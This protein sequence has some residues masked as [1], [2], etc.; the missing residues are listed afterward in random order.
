MRHLQNKNKSPSAAP[1]RRPAERP[2]QMGAVVSDLP[3]E[4]CACG[5]GCP[6]CRAEAQSSS[7]T[8]FMG[9][10]R[11]PAEH[12]ADQAAEPFM[13]LPRPD[14]KINSAVS[15]VAKN[16]PS[17]SSTE[18]KEAPAVVHRALESP[19]QPLDNDTRTV[20]ESHFR[21]SF[22]DVRVHGD[23]RGAASARA[24]AADAYAVGNDLVFGAGKYAPATL[25]GRHLLAHELAHVA[26]HE[27]APA[28]SPAILR[29]RP[30]TYGDLPSVAQYEWTGTEQRKTNTR[31]QQ[32]N[33]SLAYNAATG[34][35]T[36][37]FH[38][39]W[40]FPL[41]WAQARRDAYRDDF[42][43]VVKAAWENKFPL[44]KWENGKPTSTT[45][46]VLLDFD[47]ITAPDMG[48][49]DEYIQWLMNNNDPL[50]NQRWTMNIHDSF[51]YRDKVDAPNVHLDPGSNTPQTSDTSSFKDKTY[52]SGP[53]GAVQPPPYQ[54]YFNQGITPSQGTAPQGKYTQT[55][56]VH[57]FGH[58]IGLADEYVMSADDYNDLVAA[59]GQSVADTE[60]RKRTKASTRVENMGNQVTKD[61][62]RP[63]ADF[64]HTLTAEDWRVQ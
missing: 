26:Q 24:V 50:N 36:C 12:E 56:S 14:G 20:M 38:L 18:A 31:I 59:K 32:S 41:S 28:G 62:Y 44:V 3:P 63:F 35:F 51:T 37:T 9:S 54:H 2:S 34:D 60:L 15:P 45:A 48:N 19:G 4:T 61:A 16:Y 8:L 55:A 21:R 25:A 17:P 7:T 40:R 22:A 49:D 29:R 47:H 33:V 42:V 5:G 46:Q 27:T 52:T 43:K 58:M 1:S 13:R 53:G 10:V 23:A 30:I 11:D 39:R 57:E 6:R 64:L